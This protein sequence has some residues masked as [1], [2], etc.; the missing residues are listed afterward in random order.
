MENSEE[1]NPEQ[2]PKN[3]PIVVKT[4]WAKAISR[5]GVTAIIVPGLVFIIIYFLNFTGKAFKA[6]DK[7]ISDRMDEISNIASAFKTGSVITEFTSY[8]T[9]IRANNYLQVAQLETV[10]SFSKSETTK[11]AWDL[12]KFSAEVEIRAPVEYTFY[13]DL[14]EK[15]A[16]KF[17]LQNEEAIL[18]NQ[19]ENLFRVPEIVVRAPGIQWNK[20]AIDISEMK[21]WENKSI[22]IDEDKMRNELQKEITAICN[23]RAKEKVNLVRE[24]ARA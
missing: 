13:L 24:I 10:E 19:E 21:V 15:E 12:I 8:A 14:L 11:H 9:K 3:Q 18:K 5:I 1:T 17:E 20:P 16:W 2:P 4:T 6:T 23:E 22:G 7:A